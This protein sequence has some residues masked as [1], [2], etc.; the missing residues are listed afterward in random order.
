[1]VMNLDDIDTS[2][3]S[4]WSFPDEWFKVSRD[5]CPVAK[6]PGDAG[7]ILTRY[8]DVRSAS[9]RIKAAATLEV[10]LNFGVNPG[11]AAVYRQW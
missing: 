1:M 6:I 7:V 11:I 2:D 3:P 10:M 9:M 4:F 8:D 5:Q